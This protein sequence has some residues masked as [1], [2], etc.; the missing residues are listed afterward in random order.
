VGSLETKKQLLLPKCRVEK[1]GTTAD[2]GSGAD[3]QLDNF[4]SDSQKVELTDAISKLQ[5]VARSP[6]MIL[7]G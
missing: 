1:Y 4:V 3:T 2:E 5:C 6:E 7:S